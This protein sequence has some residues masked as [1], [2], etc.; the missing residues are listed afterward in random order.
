MVTL[1]LSAGLL[2]RSGG[3]RNYFLYNAPIYLPT[4]DI[5]PFGQNDESVQT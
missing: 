2:Y 1:K 5:K 3:V 4:K